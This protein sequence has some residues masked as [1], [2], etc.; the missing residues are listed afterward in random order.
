MGCNQDRIIQAESSKYEV[1]NEIRKWESESELSSKVFLDIVYEI[2]SK[3]FL[4]GEKMSIEKFDNYFVKTFNKRITKDFFE[5]EFFLADKDKFDMLKVKNLMLLLTLPKKVITRK[6][7]FY[8]DKANYLFS[9]VKDIDNDSNEFIDKDSHGLRNFMNDVVYISIVFIPNLW[10][11]SV[12]DAYKYKEDKLFT[13]YSKIEKIAEAL[14]GKMFSILG[15]EFI[16]LSNLNELYDSI[17]GFLTAAYI[18]DFALEMF[19]I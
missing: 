5:D 18:R 16:T 2:N 15:T 17:K 19:N 7:I 14:I 11:K 6:N 9:Y 8:Y 10:M 13:L 4:D 12:K 3:I 1:E